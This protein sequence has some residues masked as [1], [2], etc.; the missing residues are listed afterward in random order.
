MEYLSDDIA[1]LRSAVLVNMTWAAVGI[2]ILW[3]IASDR[4]QYYASQIH[5]LGP[6]VQR[7]SL[8]SPNFQDRGVPKSTLVFHHLEK[9]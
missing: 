8:R 5:V 9:R 2:S 6:K 4:R 1:S 7:E 3:S